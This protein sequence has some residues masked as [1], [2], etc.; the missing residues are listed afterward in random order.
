MTPIALPAKTIHSLRH[1]VPDPAEFTPTKFCPASTKSWFAVHYLRFVSSDFPRHQF[2]L[3]F[4]NQLMHCFGFIA[5]FD[6]IGFWTEYF[7][8]NAGKIEFLRETLA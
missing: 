8:S 7:T 4:Y 6:L 5:H 2:T 3:R 1:P